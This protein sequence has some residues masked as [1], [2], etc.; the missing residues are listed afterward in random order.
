LNK[1]QK[2]IVVPYTSLRK[3]NKISSSLETQCLFGETVFQLETKNN[4]SYCN[5]K[6]DNYNGWIKT[7]D[8]GYLPTPNYIISNINTLVFKKPDL[9]STLKC[10]LFFN[11]KI[12]VKMIYENWAE[13]ILKNNTTAF[14]PK[15]H[16]AP[17][18]TEEKNWM[19]T[20]LNFLNSPYLWGGKN[21]LGMDCSGLVQ[22]SLERAGLIIPRNSSQQL[23]LK[24][25]L[26]KST[27]LIQKGSL[28]FWKGHVA[29]AISKNEIIHSNSYHMS[30]Q[31]EA[32]DDAIHR[33]SKTVGDIIEVKQVNLSAC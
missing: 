18:A 19:K 2:K 11:S 33:F 13:I 25:N 17:I 14:V 16:I 30:V 20:A 32:L 29:I 22:I 27:Q 24:S 5:C 21:S 6:L 23:K 1:S 7:N 8:L 28:V 10:V 9:K 12:T 26:I 15:S 4:W 3:E 31:I